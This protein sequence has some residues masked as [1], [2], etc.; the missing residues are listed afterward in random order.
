MVTPTASLAI[1]T[2]PP[3]QATFDA[4]RKSS[5]WTQMLDR[6][7]RAG[8][9]DV[10]AATRSPTQWSIRDLVIDLDKDLVARLEDASV[11][12]RVIALYADVVRVRQGLL[13][14]L[15]NSVLIIAAR[16]LEIDGHATVCLDLRKSK[17]AQLLLYVGEIAGEL[18]GLPIVDNKA[19]RKM[20]ITASATAA[21]VWLHAT[22]GT[23]IL[24]DRPT[25]PSEWVQSP[26]PAWRVAE[27]TFQMAT[28]LMKSAPD[29]AKPM[30]A[31]LVRCAALVPDK[32]PYTAEW[33]ELARASTR[34]L[35][36]GAQGVEAWAKDYGRLLFRGTPALERQRKANELERVQDAKQLAIPYELLK[37]TAPAPDPWHPRYIRHGAQPLGLGELNG[38][39]RPLRSVTLTGAEIVLAADLDRSQFVKTYSGQKDIQELTIHA[40]TLVITTGLHFAQTDVT[41]HCRALYFEG[42]DAYIDTSPVDDGSREPQ[43]IDGKKGGTAGS[44][45]LH[46]ERF[47]TT[48]ANAQHFRVRGGKGQK[49]DDGGFEI[50][51]TARY[52]PTITEA[53]WSALFEYSNRVVDSGGT[54]PSPQWDTYKDRKIV[55]VELKI[56][57]K[58]RA[59]KGEKAEPGTGGAGKPPGRPGIGGDGGTLRSTL[60]EVFAFADVSGGDSA[61]A[62]GP[63]KGGAGGLPAVACW[64][65]FEDELQSGIHTLKPRVEE[66]K[67]VKGPDSAPGLPALELRGNSGH[68]E[69]LAPVLAQDSWRTELNLGVALQFARDALASAQPA[70]AREY[71]VPY[72]QDPDTLLDTGIDP[73]ADA[74]SMA[75]LTRHAND[76]AEQALRNVDDF[77]NPPGWVPMLSLES[78]VGAYLKIIRPSMA[79]LYTAYCLQHAWKKKADRLSTL[80]SFSEVLT[81]QTEKTRMTLTD[82]RASIAPVIGQLKQLMDDMEKTHQRLGDARTRIENSNDGRFKSQ[83]GKLIL[84]GAFKILGAVVKAIP[85]PE[86]YSAATAGLGMVFDTAGNFIDDH[87][88]A[89]KTLNND[90]GTFARDNADSLSTLANK[91]LENAIERSGQSIKALQKSAIE[92]KKK[93][94]DLDDAHEAR[95]AA[96]EE[97]MAKEREIYNMAKE[98]LLYGRADSIEEKERLIKEATGLTMDFQAFEQKQKT[99]LEQESGAYLDKKK[100]LAKNET[101]IKTKEQALTKQKAELTEKKAASQKS[102]KE[103]IQKMQAVVGGIESIRKSV[104]R[105]SVPKAQLNTQWDK[106]L[107][108][109]QVD[110]PEFQAITTLLAHLNLKKVEITGKLSRLQTDLTEQKNEIASNLVTV[111]ELSM[112]IANTHNVL[113]PE[114]AVYAQALAQDAHRDLQQFLYYVVKAYEY[115]CIA[116]WEARYHDAQKLFDDMRNVLEPSDFKYNFVDEEDGPARREALR[117]LL[118]EPAPEQN[119]QLSQEAFNL[120]RVVYE[121]PLRDMG[122]QLLKQL[123]VSGNTRESKTAITL[124]AAQLQ[125]LNQRIQAREPAIIPFDLVQLRQ[126]NLGKERQRIADIRV[127]KVRCRPLKA[128]G[129]FPDSLTFR[130][131]LQGK[132]LVRADGCIY[133]FEPEGGGRTT[134][135]SFETFGGKND[136]AGWRVEKDG[137]G[138]LEGE[139][140]RPPGPP[141]Q[142][143]LLAQ[144]LAGDKDPNSANLVKLSEFRPGVFS[145]FGLD[146][147][148]M[149][150]DAR[151]EFEEVEL[152]VTAEGTDAPDDQWVAC[153]GSNVPRMI[154]FSTSKAD[155]AGHRGGL[156]QY[157][158]VFRRADAP[159][160]I[161]VPLNVGEFRHC[162]WLIDGEPATREPGDKPWTTISLRQSSYVVALYEAAQT[163]ADA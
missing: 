109:L 89:F 103:G 18:T 6:G 35:E 92:T 24:E 56:G 70:L 86:P 81:G 50:S 71:L 22:Q 63:S 91:D 74:V 135:V 130:F 143:S 101:A 17:N 113:A 157:V 115:Q 73:Q 19:P 76:L 31:H 90:L 79:E 13:L 11:K 104:D 99:R 21:G 65:F 138:V 28:V 60:D 119:G 78:T 159:V 48:E 87:E 66:R 127:T 141:T 162:G 40:D 148:V 82:T 75:Q 1:D 116:P 93:N 124:R 152:I 131:T 57:G 151:V 26:S 47:G 64:V 77:G 36:T 117:K 145:D 153:V 105:L 146:V 161:S 23:P 142:E 133:A 97:M 85:L 126:L 7:R 80:E 52:L 46:V 120:L 49:P 43:K 108:Q 118:N 14:T 125:A 12:P 61:A 98:A 72:L 30:L 136:K 128:G 37:A 112:E 42:P 20:V 106:A 44:I 102:I 62:I 68:C 111:H 154:A 137:A 114:V 38:V 9:R 69:R 34:L 33:K 2:L 139:A 96:H 123:M 129:D 54:V 59:T 3:W 15:D 160:E 45:T 155:L 83:Q 58:I 107:A 121:K 29:M 158:G 100:A 163:P 41:I 84:A 140:L 149:P 25:L 55:Y 53:E 150:P 16:R 32:A 95:S 51:A 134:A 94:Q 8:I 39:E 110:D 67:A 144:L 5:A 147:T 156:G 88:T 132:S 27:S 122:K 10:H 4:A